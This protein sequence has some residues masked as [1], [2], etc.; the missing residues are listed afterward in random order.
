[1]FSFLIAGD[2]GDTGSSYI[3]FG[4]PDTSVMTSESDIVW[5]ESTNVGG[6]WSNYVTGWKY[7]D[8]SVSIGTLKTWALTDTGSSCI[9]GP[10]QVIDTILK[11]AERRII[12]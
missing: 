5:L 2:A 8:S 4:T 1:M 9:H 10:S 12:G 11:D 6:W 3:D 7:S